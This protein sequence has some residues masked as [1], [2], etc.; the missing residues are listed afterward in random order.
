[1]DFVE[2]ALKILG[3]IGTN[4]QNLRLLFSC[5]DKL[6]PFV[7][8]GLSTDFGY[9]GWNKLIQGLAA[10]T[11][12]SRLIRKVNDLLDNNKFE[13][14]AEEVSRNLPNLF[15]DTLRSAFD[16][17]KLVRPLRHSAVCHIPYIADGP[18]LT[19]NFDRVLEAA[20]QDA[21]HPFKEVF[22]GSRIREAHR[23]IQLGEPFL[24]K[25]H[26]DYLDSESRVLTLKQYVRE[27]GHSDPGKVNLS[28][29]VPSVLGQALAA[30]PLFFV[31]CS[32]KTDRT[33]SV[34]GRLAM[35]MPGTIHFALMSESDNSA[36]RRRQLEV[37]NI[38]PIFY[39]ERQY[40]KIEKLLG[41]LAVNCPLNL[42][43]STVFTKGAAKSRPKLENH[44][45]RLVR[46]NA[47]KLFYF[48]SAAHLS[49][50][51]LSNLAGINPQLLGRI[52]KPRKKSGPFG[53]QSFRE[54]EAAV[55]S[56]IERILGCKD[57]L[58]AG[59]LDDFLSQ[60]TLFYIRH[61]VKNRTQSRRTAQLEIPFQTKAIVFDFDGTLTD[62]TDDWTTW[63]KI[64]T[65]LRYPVNDCAELHRR[66]MRKEFT[67]QEWCDMTRDK[68]KARRFS[69]K[70]L[71]RII[72]DTSLIKGTAETIKR[73]K[74]RS[75][76]LYILSGS[77]KQVI[78]GCLDDLYD[79]F[80]EVK[81]NELVFD[82]SGVI[83][84]IIGTR[85]DF[86]GKAEFLKRIVA[87]NEW[88]N[89]DVLFVGNSV[90]D[91]W[92]SLAGVRT[93]CVNPRFTRPDDPAVWTYEIR[94]MGDL[95]EIMKYVQIGE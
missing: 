65:S 21:G 70:H 94:K 82:S 83:S 57:K 64:W 50:K 58:R 89:W 44:R 49:I 51:E 27:Y 23:A 56:R 43:R 8:A 55:L 25:L 42:S 7:G 10:Q 93:L 38:R 34:I 31:G 61:K 53:L 67:H 69:Q 36:E 18:V 24:L 20:F 19:T 76:R 26:G 88:S 41:C 17:E 40:D 90:N 6:V 32:L 4:E 77:I 60:Y 3:N 9:P 22:P 59:K 95:G 37:W 54:C 87:E 35:Q 92:A 45:Q 30:R 91:D 85:F 14:A 13:E 71:E 66:F 80:D 86:W 5:R 33:I 11:S 72:R 12:Q 47:Y 46:V 73:L 62:T 29:A 84:K 79:S 1:M 16:H 81:A 48:R 52:E 78:R 63:E 2:D 75:I 68:F 15:D 39:P 28:R 74:S